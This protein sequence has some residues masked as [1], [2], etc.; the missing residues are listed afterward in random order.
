[1]V[2]PIVLRLRTF[3]ARPGITNRLV[4]TAAHLGV[5][6]LDKV[7]HDDWRPSPKAT[8]AF[9]QALDKLEAALE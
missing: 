8:R 6:A 3:L 1:M 5:R 2:D 4:V 7:N 9:T